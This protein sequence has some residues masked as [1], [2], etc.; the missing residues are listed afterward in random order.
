[1]DLAGTFL[2]Y[3]GVEA[4]AGMTTTSLRGLLS[5]SGHYFRDYISSG[6]QSMPFGR[7]LANGWVKGLLTGRCACPKE[8]GKT[9]VVH[10]K[11]NT[12]TPKCPS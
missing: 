3:A 7:S 8:K 6:L 4:D 12:C 1:M 2:D 11:S 10:L 9:R 5:G